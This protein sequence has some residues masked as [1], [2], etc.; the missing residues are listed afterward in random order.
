MASRPGLL[1]TPTV[2]KPSSVLGVRSWSIIGGF[3]ANENL[4]DRDMRRR[5]LWVVALLTLLMANQLRPAPGEPL[6]SQVALEE[7]RRN[8]VASGHRGS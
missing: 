7:L 8:R 1:T 2:T 6:S 4:Y 5:V 3:D